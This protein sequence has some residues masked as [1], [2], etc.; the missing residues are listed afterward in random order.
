MARPTKGKMPQIRRTPI[1]VRHVITVDINVENLGETLYKARLRSGKTITE[2]MGQIGITESYWGQV[3][4]GNVQTIPLDR[5]IK[6][7]EILDCDL[8]LDWDDWIPEELLPCKK[9]RKS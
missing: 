6:I 1:T 7:Q 3:I 8:G 4:R 2:I 5:L 9:E